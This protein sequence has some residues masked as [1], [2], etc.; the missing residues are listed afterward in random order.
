MIKSL[1]SCKG[2]CKDIALRKLPCSVLRSCGM[3]TTQASYKGSSGAFI[4][5]DGGIV[6][7]VH[8]EMS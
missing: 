6:L 8:S 3:S 5:T 7:W 1:T 4:D 2:R